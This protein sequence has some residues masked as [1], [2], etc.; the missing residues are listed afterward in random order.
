MVIDFHTHLFQKSV[1]E[2]RESYF[3]GEPGFRLLYEPK[4]AKLVGAETLIAAMDEQGVDKSVVFGF[5]WQNS[6]TA[7]ENNDYIL[8]SISRF[9]DRLIGFCCVDV[10]GKGAVQEVERCL[11]NGMTGVGEL[12]FYGSGIDAAALDRLDPIMQVCR[13]S[14]RVI[15]IH[16]NEPV[17]HMYPGKSP[18]TLGQIFKLVSRFPDNR[19]VLAHWGGGIFFYNLMKREVKET[20]KNVYFDTAASPFLY[21]PGIYTQAIAL[22]GMD[23]ILFGTD[24]PL[25]SPNRYFK[26]MKSAGLTDMEFGALC[27]ENAKKLLGL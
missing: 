15:L 25:L 27:G 3:D 7:K 17:G 4:N 21:D 26:E 8:D 24:Y 10:M 16:T 5:P 22:A 9:P 19:I 12:A 1:R 13:T 18:I 20:L 11:E 6:E 2:N 23:K 14:G